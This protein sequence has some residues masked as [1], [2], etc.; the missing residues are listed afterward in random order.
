MPVY[1][2]STIAIVLLA[3]AAMFALDQGVQRNAD[4]AFSSPSSV[5]L[6]DHGNTHNLVGLD[7]Y[8]AKNHGWGTEMP[9]GN[10]PA[11]NPPESAARK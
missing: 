8:S 3:F 6:S 1:F 7:W 4:E 5:R 11:A 2:A 9:T 10:S